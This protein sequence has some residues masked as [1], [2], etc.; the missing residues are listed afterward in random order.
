MCIE[1]Y[2][3]LK[4]KVVG[5]GAFGLGVLVRRDQQQVVEEEY[6]DAQRLLSALESQLALAHEH[7]VGLDEVQGLGRDDLALNVQE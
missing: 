4:D 3:L 1:R 7:A 2:L 5:L 6:H